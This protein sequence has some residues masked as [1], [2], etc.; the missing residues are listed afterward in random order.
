MGLEEDQVTHIYSDR[1]LLSLGLK[2]GKGWAWIFIIEGLATVIA[3]LF[4]YRVIQD[5]PD[6]AK[7]LTEEERT[8]IMCLYSHL[9][10][11]IAIIRCLCYSPPAR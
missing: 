2:N 7:F 10:S 11:I 1:L 9:L 4:S 3:A 5:F 8:L 6:T